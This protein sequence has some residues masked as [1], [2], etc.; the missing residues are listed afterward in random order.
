VVDKQ[1][2][3]KN[4]GTALR[5]VRFK[6]GLSMQQLATLAEMEKSQ[7]Y[8]IENGKVDVRMSTL[9]TLAEALNVELNDFLR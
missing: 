9:Y 6:R 3:A 1:Q 4:I 5:N 8:R 2:I 7:I